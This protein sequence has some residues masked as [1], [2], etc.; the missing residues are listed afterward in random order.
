MKR[1]AFL[2]VASLLFQTVALVVAASPSPVPAPQETSRLVISF[3]SVA[4]G[5][6]DSDVKAM[7]SLLS[8]YE[9][10]HRV[11]LE[12]TKSTYGMEGDFAYCFALAELD[13]QDQAELVRS[14]RSLA[15]SLKQ[16]SV[17][18]NVLCPTSEK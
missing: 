14:I 6:V 15:K 8:K 7:D 11:F 3:Y 17:V 9:T 1:P 5:P 13:A 18:E 4:S 12:K 10:D 16:V 2:T